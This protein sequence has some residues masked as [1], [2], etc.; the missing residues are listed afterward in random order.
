V[1]SEKNEKPLCSK[2]FRGGSYIRKIIKKEYRLAATPLADARVVG[3]TRKK[4]K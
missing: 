2:A 4:T 1:L 3:Q